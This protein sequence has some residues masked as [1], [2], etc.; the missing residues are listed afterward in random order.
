[1]ELKD[2]ILRLAKFWPLFAILTIGGV[3]G[4]LVFS[5]LQTP[6]YKTSV[7]IY[8]TPIQDQSLSIG[9][10][11]FT[12]TLLGV[13]A[14]QNLG[15]DAVVTSRKIAPQ[16]IEFTISAANREQVLKA[17]QNLP[18]NLGIVLGQTLGENQVRLT[19]LTQEVKISEPANLLL[20]NILV[21][22]LAGFAIGAVLVST[23]IYFKS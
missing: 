3:F 10:G 9:A 2:F 15:E 21:G 19:L 17:S 11:E 1:M 18:Q 23:L 6:V 5:Q 4:G 12:D 22:A 7:S 14:S 20:L 16:I 8:F 13:L